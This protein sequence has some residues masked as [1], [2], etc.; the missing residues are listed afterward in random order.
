MSE[1]ENRLRVLEFALGIDSEMA[2]RC[3][4]ISSGCEEKECE[5]SCPLSRNHVYNLVDK[6]SK[7]LDEQLILKLWAEEMERMGIAPASLLD[8]AR[9]QVLRRYL[10]VKV[11]KMEAVASSLGPGAAEFH[12]SLAQKKKTLAELDAALAE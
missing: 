1:V 6:V 12:R 9:L 7:T 11:E 3:Q 2:K 5:S 8:K 4:G 10:V